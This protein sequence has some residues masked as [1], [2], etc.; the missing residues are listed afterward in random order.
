MVSTPGDGS[1]GI[2]TYTRDLRDGLGEVESETIPIPQD[3][4]SARQFCRLAL[5][6]VQAGGEVIHVQH[7]Y[8]LF[9]RDGSDHPGVMGFVFFPI[10]FALAS[11]RSQ[12]VVITMHSVIDLDPDDAALPVR[13]S[14]FLMHKLIVLGTSHV[15]FLAPDCA[16][17]F[18]SQVSLPERHFSVLSHGVKTD[19]PTSDSEADARRELGYDADDKVVVIPGFMRPP[20]GHDIFVE[21]AR[22]LPEYEFL[23]AGGARPKGEDFEFARK[24]RAD[25]PENVRI[26]GVLDDRDF[27]NALAVPDLALLPYRVVTQ[28]GTFNC[29][30]SQGLP[31]LASDAE[32][33]SRIAS[34]WGA[35]ETVPLDDPQTVTERVRTLLEDDARRAALGTAM[36]RYKEANSF[37]TVGRD[38]VRIYRGVVAG[39]TPETA[40]SVSG[41][42]DAA[43]SGQ[44]SVSP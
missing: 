37:E 35:P 30:A 17:S 33:F 4:R 34:T 42:E 2:G 27:W 24:I 3:D 13:T 20:K 7:E 43:C 16:S 38:H 26:T 25:A 44:R 32:Y 5:D 23:V 6:A 39:R 31:V 22:R 18:R 12:K 40:P 36:G 9:R 1:C 21:V 8:G 14:L 28:S 41:P 10:V 15:I 11:L 29:C 19:L